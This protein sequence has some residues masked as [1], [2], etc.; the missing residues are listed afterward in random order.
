MWTPL[1][2]FL[3]ACGHKCFRDGLVCITCER[4]QNVDAELTRIAEATAKDSD[5]EWMQSLGVHYDG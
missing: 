5:R 1:P 3:C 2:L 4:L